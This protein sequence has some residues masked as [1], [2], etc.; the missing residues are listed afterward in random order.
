MTV[1]EQ[2]IL[3]Q[4]LY[5]T[6]KWTQK[7]IRGIVDV[8]EKTIGKW[9]KKGSW[10]HIRQTQQASKPKLLMNA[11]A[12]MMCITKKINEEMGGIP[13]KHLSD[14]K[15][16]CLREIEAFDEHRLQV[17]VDCFEDFSSWLMHIEPKNGSVFSQLMM[18]FLD[19]KMQ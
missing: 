18:R 7:A 16:Q 1:D 4:T 8:G 17:Y 10:E 11:Y 19:Y 5:M 13:D 14:A 2:K 12:Q 9:A 15:A 6:G 3:A